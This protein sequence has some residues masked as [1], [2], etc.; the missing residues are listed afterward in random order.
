MQSHIVPIGSD[1]VDIVCKY[2]NIMVLLG[3][4]LR[5]CAEKQRSVTIEY[6]T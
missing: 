6:A 4:L 1:L 3:S 2:A 5:I